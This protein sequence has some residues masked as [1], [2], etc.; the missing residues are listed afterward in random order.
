M[1]L[2][3]FVKAKGFFLAREN[4]SLKHTLLSTLFILTSVCK[5]SYVS[6]ISLAP[7]ESKIKSTQ[8]NATNAVLTALAID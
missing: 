6:N 5:H 8:N 3:K 2:F 4:P 1:S 7:Q